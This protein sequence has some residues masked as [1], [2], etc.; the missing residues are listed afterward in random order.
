MF[1]ELLTAWENWQNVI[2]AYFDHPTMNVHA[3]SLKIRVMR[4]SVEA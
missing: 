2:L 1:T 4:V 3:E